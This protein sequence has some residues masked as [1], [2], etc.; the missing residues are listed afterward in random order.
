MANPE[1][2]YEHIAGRLR[3]RIDAGALGEGDRLPSV[4]AMSRQSGV[5]VGTVVQAYQRL[6][7][8]G[9]IVARPQSG[10][11]VHSTRLPAISRTRT[12]QPPPPRP[13]SQT[14]LDRVIDVY[15]RT[16]LLP[17]HSATPAAALLPTTRMAALSRDLLRRMP[18]QISGYVHPPG[19]RALRQQVARRLTLVGVDVD[20][21][22]VVITAGALEAITL[23]LQVLTRP[24]DAVLVERPTYY[25]LLQALAARN[26]KVVE[27]PNCC[28][29]GPDLECALKALAGG[30]IRAALLIP[31]F[32]NPSG[33]L[34]PIAARTRLLQACVAAGVP[35]IEDDV[36]GE[37][38]FDGSRPSPIKAFDEDDQTILCGSVSKTLGPGLRIGWA[39]SR[40]WREDLIRAKSFTSCSAPTLG[41]YVA[42]EMLSGNNMERPLQ[43]LRSALRANVARF[44][45]VIASH[46]PAGTAVSDPQGGL[47]LWLKLPE[48]ASGQAL[49]ERALEA[50]IG[51]V[52][53]T[54][55]SAGNYHRDCLRLSCASCTWSPELEAAL[56]R[57]GALAGAEAT[58]LG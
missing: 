10:Y 28:D 6:E 20:A 43:R 36:Y 2:L 25:G 29:Q 44:R 30:Q 21:D 4:R 56:Q 54:L 5:S 18:D 55:F 49:F 48:G 8:L 58:G 53:G 14:L 41:Q 24:G 37:L 40:R 23:S 15:A 31:N 42:A 39:V 47:V 35:V 34:M 33:A 26:L 51:I 52:P 9:V 38:A 3:Q 19:L 27:I 17:L 12:Q 11:Y 57:L 22:D 16:D 32:S 13:L 50:G 7:A 45:G 1:P 46:W